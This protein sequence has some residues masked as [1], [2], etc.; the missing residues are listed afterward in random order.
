MRII[1]ESGEVSAQ[2]EIP[3]IKATGEE[4]TWL[5]STFAQLVKEGILGSRG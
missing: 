2:I 5:A 3:E 4:L 1:V